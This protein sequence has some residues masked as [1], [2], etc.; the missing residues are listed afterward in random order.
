MMS[1][2]TVGLAGWKYGSGKVAAFTKAINYENIASNENESLFVRLFLN[3]CLWATRNNNIYFYSGRTVSIIKT[4]NTIFDNRLAS[5]LSSLQIF[6][7]VILSE[8]WYLEESFQDQNT[9]FNLYVLI[10]SYSAFGGVKMPDNRQ[11]RL[12][13]RVGGGSGL[14]IA[15]WFHLLQSI[16]T[17]RSFSFSNNASAGLFTI[18]P[19]K[20]EKDFLV[21]SK[22][23]ELLYV[24]AMNDES[25]SST[26]PKTFIL[27]NIALD[28]PFTG[29]IVQMDEAKDNATIYWAT[30]LS[31]SATTTTTTTTTTAIPAT[32]EIKMKIG[33]LNLI[34]SCGP[35][36]LYLDGP[37]KNYFALEGDDLYLT[38]YM[39]N[40]EKILLNVVAEDY[41]LSQRFNKIVET[42]EIDFV[43][44]FAPISRPK[45]GSGPAF[46]FRANGPI[47]AAWGQFAPTGIITPFDDYFFVGEGKAENPA[48][49]AIGGTHGDYNALWMQV[50]NGGTISYSITASTESIIYH[51]NYSF[52]GDVGGLFLIKNTK[53][54]N[55]K[56]SQHN[57]D[58]FSSLYDYQVTSVYANQTVSN[59]LL[60]EDPNELDENDERVRGDVFLILYLR[61]DIINSERDDRVY[62]TLYFG[63]T[64]T[65]PPPQ[66]AYNVIIQNNVPQSTTTVNQLTFINKAQNNIN[67]QQFFFLIPNGSLVLE[68]IQAI[69]TSNVINVTMNNVNNQKQV[70]VTLTSMPAGG[71]LATVVLNG[72]TNTTTTTAPPPQYSITVNML[73]KV[74]NVTLNNPSNT[75][76]AGYNEVSTYTFSSV[77]GLTF[78]TFSYA[79]FSGYEY[80]DNNKPTVFIDS[81]N[82][83]DM[84]SL[85][86]SN[87]I[88]VNRT[89]NINGN[90]SVPII[91][92]VG[93]GTIDLELR[94]PDPVPTTTTTTT[95]TPPPCDNSIYIICQQVLDCVEGAGGACTPS[96]NSYQQLIFSTCC[97]L[98][99]EQVMEIIR[100]YNNASEN[101]TLDDMYG[102][103]C[104]LTITEFFAPCLPK[105]SNGDCQET[106][107]NEIIDVISCGSQ[108]N[109]LP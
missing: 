37:Y 84:V 58:L 76:P 38:K 59:Y 109:P 34:N 91:V 60:I 98:T 64:T 21:F 79:V 103:E 16:P 24:E 1:Q 10:P 89:S 56:P 106:F 86:G 69:P 42:L 63:T 26:V 52:T 50:N 39:E 55:I 83:A 12:I 72:A 107:H 17:K 13:N 44:C 67:L 73:N 14:I 108:F 66:F 104:G 75:D 5:L 46:S 62:T 41:F 61:K 49:A 90:I 102:S 92:P 80:R 8:P 32:E 57:T 68:N 22:S 105:D 27:N 15:E 85:T 9:D 19:L 36:K 96:A 31:G 28:T 25:I 2:Q 65:T 43:N 35:Q 71:G 87:P 6:S 53:T 4:T 99:N 70:V 23:S 94:S 7:S 82:P 81:Q 78:N 11:Q 18:S 54:S 30:D 77:A 74:N 47:K 3:A 20:I 29:H 33:K 88:T 93:G 100:E 97:G 51:N 40:E 48:I 45:D 95:T 101:A